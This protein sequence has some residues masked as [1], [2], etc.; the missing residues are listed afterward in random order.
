M[1][2]E[3]RGAEK[4]SRDYHRVMGGLVFY[5]LC[6]G[7]FWGMPTRRGRE[8]VPFHHHKNFFSPEE[9]LFPASF[10]HFNTDKAF[11]Y[12]LITSL[13]VRA[14]LILKVQSSKSKQRPEGSSVGKSN[15]SEGTRD[16]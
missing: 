8:G 12:L 2:G 10:Q 5:R 9:L 13:I 15:L 1:G 14:I 6:S 7:L 16:Q 4:Q 3:E 11:R